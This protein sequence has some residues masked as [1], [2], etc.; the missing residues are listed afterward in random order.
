MMG[1]ERIV[2]LHDSFVSEILLDFLRERQIPVF[3]EGTLRK[4]LL[5]K[6]IPVLS[7]EEAERILSSGDCIAYSNA[8]NF[9]PFISE[10]Y[11]HE[12]ANAIKIFKNKALFRRILSDFFPDFYF[13][14][15]KVEETERFKPP[16]GKEL[17]LKPAVGFW[18]V[19]IRKFSNQNGYELAVLEAMKEIEAQKRIF[20]SSI[21]NGATFLV[22]EVIDGREFACDAYF[23]ETGKPVVLGIYCH[24]FR[25]RGDVRDLVYYTGKKVLEKTLGHVEGFLL[26]LSEKIRLVN[27][28]IHFEFIIN[29]RNELVPVEVNPMRFGGFGL[30]DLTFHCF[31]INPYECYFCDKKPDWKNILAD[32]SGDYHGFVL[33]R[34]EGIRKP[35]LPKFRQTFQQLNRFVEMD[36]LKSPVFCVAYTQSNDL[37][38]IT[39]YVYF[40]FKEYESQPDE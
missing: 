23:D 7:R 18:S 40:D 35:N 21:I 10:H 15:I 25:D 34:N 37:N 22:E 9:I 20:D 2:L 27:F 38:E 28:P 26:A 11:A 14:E 33:G 5:E 36:Y 17:I 24:H 32:A 13:K 30:V 39:K 4:K 19:G 12:S 6:K 31:G 3:T 1:M 16:S 29:N 8:E